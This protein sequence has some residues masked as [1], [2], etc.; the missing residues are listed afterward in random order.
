MRSLSMAVAAVCSLSG[1]LLTPAIPAARADEAAPAASGVLNVAHRGAAG[2]AP[3][4]TLAALDRSVADHADRLSI[5]VRLTGDGVPIVM[6]D[7]SLA[8]TTDVEQ[9]FPDSSSY[10][11]QDFTLAQVKRLDAGSWFGE[12]AFTGSRV[13]TLDE[14]L[15]EL[16][17]S[18]VGLTVEIKQPRLADGVAG[19][20]EAVMDVLGRHPEWAPR[21]GRPP[22]LLV[23]SF[24][25]GFLDAMHA[26]YPE[27]PLVLLGN[28]LPEDI[29]AHPYV[30]EID[31]PSAWLDQSVVDSAH[32]RGKRLGVW[33]VNDPD[34]IEYAVDILADGVTNDHPDLVRDILARR[35][36]SWTGTAW[37]EPAPA[38]KAALDFVGS[39]LLDDSLLQV[40]VR[41][42]DASGA[43]LRWRRV[44]F[45]IRTGTTWKTVAVNATDAH[46][47]AVVS[48]PKTDGMAVR[49]VVDGRG[50]PG[51]AP[52]L[53]LPSVEVPPGALPPSYRIAAQPLAAVSGAQP[54]VSL[55][56]ASIW[57]QATGR[58]W[59]RGCPVG[60]SG[61]RLLSVSYWGLDGHR[62]RGSLLVARQTA[63]QL[64]RVF[65]KLY[66]EGH[67]LRSIRRVEALGTW[68][69]G[70][71]RA[72]RGD[73]TFGFT[74]H[75]TPGDVRRVGSHARGTV[76]T[77]NPWEN[78]TRTG[79]SGS[80]NTWWLDRTRLLPYVH[81]Q[82]NAVVAAFTEQGFAWNGR[83]GRYAEFR[84]VQ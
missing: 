6:H 42:A 73:A 54:R 27:L 79:T 41:P 40:R 36:E 64:A 33:T 9:V 48:L 62:R 56:S 5:D 55:V 69:T 67:R 49:A 75:R 61:L 84:D 31:V 76:V 1:M 63:G 82:E 72:L 77:V 24:H 68:Q 45:Q 43:P 83:T 32:S 57:R 26:T 60:R 46:G 38:A 22:R 10:S 19:I 18:P 11:T 13:L 17:D 81:V 50:F 2:A 59:R 44:T 20:G 16:A 47:S 34:K 12:G 71:G 35:G 74:C 3:E 39:R 23:E 21:K 65:D 51:V 29:D 28:V 80:P 37:P 14:V 25:W 58:S 53:R 78:P 30:A 70:V 7:D 66:A 8:R 52:V 4:H 15:T